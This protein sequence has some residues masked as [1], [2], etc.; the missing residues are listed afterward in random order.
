MFHGLEGGSGS[1]YAVALMQEVAAREADEVRRE[2][3]AHLARP[4]RLLWINVEL[5]TDP[6]WDAAFSPVAGE[7]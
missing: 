4:G 2:V 1:H 6:L 7:G 5:H 3:M